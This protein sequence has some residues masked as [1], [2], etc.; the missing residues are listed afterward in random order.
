MGLVEAAKCAFMSHTYPRNLSELYKIY[1]K[2]RE[3]IQSYI[4]KLLQCKDDSN[5]HVFFDKISN[6]WIDEWTLYIKPQGGSGIVQVSATSS[7]QFAVAQFTLIVFQPN[8]II[9][10]YCFCGTEGNSC[11]INN[12]R[13]TTAQ[14]RCDNN[15]YI[16]LQSSFYVR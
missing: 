15:S 8:V 16:F 7:I 14:C 4:T 5:K 11:E 6:A 1:K 13:V 3:N 9:K 12:V 10:V 2:C